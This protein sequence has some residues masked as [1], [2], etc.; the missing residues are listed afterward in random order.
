MGRRD[1][2]AGEPRALA[3]LS[4]MWTIGFT[5]TI[6]RGA[7]CSTMDSSV[8]RRRRARPITATSAAPAITRCSCSTSRPGALRAAPRHAQRTTDGVMLVPVANVT[9]EPSE[10]V[11][12]TG[13]LR[14]PRSR[15]HALR[16]PAAANKVLQ[17]S[18]AHLLKR[19]GC[20]RACG[21]EPQAPP[22][23]QRSSGSAPSSTPASGQERRWTVEPQVRPQCVR[24]Y[25]SPTTS[26]T[27]CAPSR[28][29][30]VE[31]WSL[32]SLREKLIKIGAKSRCWPPA[33]RAHAGS[34]TARTRAIA[35]CL[36]GARA[37]AEPGVVGGAREGAARAP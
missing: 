15:R 28:C 22:R 2:A 7:W 3:D 16:H 36:I 12:L 18:I 10:H 30:I 31:Q 27:S 14:L 13:D 21:P 17:E 9:N 19:P 24:P 11:L 32:T 29:P 34:S 25:G 26:A 35:K 4:G 20:P 33:T 5:T 8:R 37:H 6:R 23:F 1:R